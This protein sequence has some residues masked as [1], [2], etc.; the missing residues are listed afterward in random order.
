VFRENR[1]VMPMHWGRRLAWRARRG[2]WPWT[3]RSC[4]L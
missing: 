1:R 4:A 2:S 3:D